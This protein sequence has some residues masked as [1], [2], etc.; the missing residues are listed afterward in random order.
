[1]KTGNYQYVSQA[2]SCTEPIIHAY[3]YLFSKDIAFKSFHSGSLLFNPTTVLISNMDSNEIT[4]VIS[5]YKI[6]VLRRQFKQWIYN[7]FSNSLGL[8]DLLGEENICN[9]EHLIMTF[10]KI[11]VLL[12]SAPCHLWYSKIVWAKDYDAECSKLLGGRV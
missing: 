1:M 7:G 8:F 11:A 3:I 12:V 6:W 4:W 10:D 2:W 9:Y 5:G